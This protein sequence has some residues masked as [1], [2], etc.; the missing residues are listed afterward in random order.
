MP[1]LTTALAA[2]AVATAPGHGCHRPAD[3]AVVP[4]G[5]VAMAAG[6]RVPMRWRPSDVDAYRPGGRCSLPDGTVRWRHG[7]L[8]NTSRGR[9]VAFYWL[10]D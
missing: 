2:L 7:A 6:E 4:S 10:E 5:A 9:V 1:V 8:V 3:W